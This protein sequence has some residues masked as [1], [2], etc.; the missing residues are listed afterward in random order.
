MKNKN[1]SVPEKVDLEKDKFYVWCTC[2]RSE[3]L[4]F[5]DGA[6]KGTTDKPHLFKVEESKEYFLC[7]CGNTKNRPF[8]DGSHNKL[9]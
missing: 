7:K 9:K 5:C 6:H 4:P 2:G 3:K 1:N 8:C